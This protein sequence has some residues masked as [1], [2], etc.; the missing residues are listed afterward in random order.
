MKSYLKVTFSSEGAKPSEVVDKLFMIGLKAT[1]GNYDFVYEW[2]KNATVK[3]TIWF[4]DKIHT[5]LK[6]TKIHFQM[7]TVGSNEIEPEG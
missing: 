4:A 5:A 6:G 2:D 7:E 3:D 1:K